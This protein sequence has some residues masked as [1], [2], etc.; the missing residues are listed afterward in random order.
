MNYNIRHEYH[1]DD[2]ITL[3]TIKKRFVAFLINWILLVIIYCSPPDT[4]T[5]FIPQ[6][7]WKIQFLN[8]TFLLPVPK[9]PV[10]KNADF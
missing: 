1:H 3:A 10:M 2:E 9:F 8:V 7:F 5:P 4:V 6:L